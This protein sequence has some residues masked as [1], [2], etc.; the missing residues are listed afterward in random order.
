M[1]VRFYLQNTHVHVFHIIQTL[2][3]VTVN[4]YKIKEHNCLM[5]PILKYQC[6]ECHQ[7]SNPIAWY[8]LLFNSFNHTVLSFIHIVL[9][10]AVHVCVCMH[11]CVFIWNNFNVKIF[12]SFPSSLQVFPKIF[13]ATYFPGLPIALYLSTNILLFTF[14]NYFVY[15]HLICCVYFIVYYCILL[16][17]KYMLILY[18][19]C[20]SYVPYLTF[21]CPFLI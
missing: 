20:L 8:I 19:P 6:G 14:N 4:R 10:K 2:H 5:C 12:S 15:V 13:L 21:I 18:V 11:V 7:R 17:T 9:T 1:Y 3:S 16:L